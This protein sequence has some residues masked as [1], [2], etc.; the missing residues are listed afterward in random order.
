[1]AESDCGSATKYGTTPDTEEELR[2]EQLRSEAREKRIPKARDKHSGSA[3]RRRAAMKQELL[4]FVVKA[5]KPC[6][7][8]H[9]FNCPFMARI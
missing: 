5:V 4:Q 2:E 9:N 7:V 1:M 3:R 8:C 6:V